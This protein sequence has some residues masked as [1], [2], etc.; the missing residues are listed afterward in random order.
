MI[1]LVRNILKD[2]LTRFFSRLT[3]IQS[4]WVV[5]G[6]LL[7]LLLFVFSLA[8]L[9][10]VFEK[11][12]EKGWKAL[13]PL[14]RIY[15]LVKISGKQWYYFLLLLIPIANIVFAFLVLFALS[16]AFEKGK[17]FAFGLFFL[18]PIFIVLLGFGDA[19]CVTVT[20]NPE[21]EEVYWVNE[22]F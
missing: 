1:T 8:G 16:R 17:G 12:G 2:L 9:W 7:V 21:D 11:A 20:H 4:I 15:V 14:Y 10:K 22:R 13:I 6:F 18:F 5:G 3:L 19:E